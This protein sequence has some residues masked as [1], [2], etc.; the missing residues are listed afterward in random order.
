MTF[1]DYQRLDAVNWSTLKHLRDSPLAYRWHR[2]HKAE[3]TDAMR[4]G[5]AT[6]TAILEPHRFLAD[7]VLWEGDR[8]AGKVWE[9]FKEAAGSRTI[10]TQTQ[11]DHALGLAEAVRSNALAMTYLRDG[12]AESTLTW[13]DAESGLA[14]KGRMDWYTRGTILDVKTTRSIDER[15]LRS[16]MESLGVFHQLAMYRMG[17]IAS[18]LAVDPRCVIL[19]V[20]SQPPHDVGVFCVSPGD[21]ETAETEVRTLLCTLRDC[22]NRNEWPGR[23]PAETSIS[24]PAWAS[25]GDIT[26][27]D[28]E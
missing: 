19:A 14:C 18:G 21:L 10:L 3:P 7:Y 25:G 8:R 24:R 22:L 26:F 27:E 16:Q 23:Y 2:E 1:A 28:E 20:E 6:H 11:Y 13:T 4:L 9:A 5:S 15:R 12:K 17:A